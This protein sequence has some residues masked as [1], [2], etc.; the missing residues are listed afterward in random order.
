MR[1][2]ADAVANFGLFSEQEG[3]SGP[4]DVM[5]RVA[6]ENSAEALPVAAPQAPR[7]AKAEPAFFTMEGL[8]LFFARVIVSRPRLGMLHRRKPM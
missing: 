8:G 4:V 5:H 2:A 3:L 1:S 6:A 7:E